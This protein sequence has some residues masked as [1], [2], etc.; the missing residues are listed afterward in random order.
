MGLVKVAV[1]GGFQQLDAKLVLG[2]LLIGLATVPG[3]FVARHLLR[4]V[5]PGGHSLLMEGVV[6]IG[7]VML[8]VRGFY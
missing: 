2:G 7:A 6:F 3:A 4:N 1:F 8:L 5:T